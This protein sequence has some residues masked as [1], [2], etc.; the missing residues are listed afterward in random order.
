MIESHDHR[1][2]R[3]LARS[4]RTKESSYLSWCGVKREVVN[5]DDI[6][7]TLSESSDLNHPATLGGSDEKSMQTA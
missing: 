5:G 6:A 7:V 1:H 3:G 4:V 2:R